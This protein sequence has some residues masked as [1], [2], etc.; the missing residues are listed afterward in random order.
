MKNKA[1]ATQV[2]KLLVGGLFTGIAILSVSA[3]ASDSTKLHGECLHPLRAEYK[4]TA[5]SCEA[6]TDQNC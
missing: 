2:R 6:L 3:A 1:N 5:A 4:A